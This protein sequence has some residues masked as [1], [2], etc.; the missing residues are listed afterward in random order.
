MDLQIFSTACADTAEA[1]G[2]RTPAGHPPV[3]HGVIENRQVRL[4][5][6]QAQSEHVSLW[7]SYFSGTPNNLVVHSGVMFY[8]PTIQ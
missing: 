6:A 8:F 3:S 7:R 4:F 2:R 1:A 5:F